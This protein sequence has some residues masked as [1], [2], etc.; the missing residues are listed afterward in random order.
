MAKSRKPLR[1]WAAMDPLMRKG[2]PHRE[3]KVKQRPRMTLSDAWQDYDDS[4]DDLH[5]L[6]SHKNGADG[7]V[8]DSAFRTSFSG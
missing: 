3:A 4:A 1:N 7:P 6:M 5:S 8:A 2:G